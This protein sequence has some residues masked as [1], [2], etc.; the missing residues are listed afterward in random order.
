MLDHLRRLAPASASDGTR[1]VAS[2][3][4]RYA[5]STPMRSSSIATPWVADADDESVQGSGDGFD[6]SAS[7]GVAAAERRAGRRSQP[8]HRLRNRGDHDAVAALE[9]TIEGN[10]R[11]AAAGDDAR[12]RASG[13]DDAGSTSFPVRDEGDAAAARSAPS[14]Y[15]ARAA[16]PLGPAAAAM[17]AARRAQRARPEPAESARTRQVP[18]E[19][20][21]IN[22]TIDRIEVRSP[23][24]APRPSSAARPR[25]AS[26]GTSLADYLRGQRRDLR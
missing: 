25:A 1:A 3:P 12:R 21:V 20:P 4:S 17:I 24:A 2:I 7:D 16:Q 5:R 23:S 13:D 8:E 22:V 15:G 10:T 11:A 14:A 18:I 9:F 19:R 6:A 26:P